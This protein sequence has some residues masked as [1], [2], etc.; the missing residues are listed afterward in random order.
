[1]SRHFK[2]VGELRKTI[3]TF[4]T[5]NQDLRCAKDD[6]K[7]Q[8]LIAVVHGADVAASAKPWHLAREWAVRVLREF[9]NQVTRVVYFVCCRMCA[10][11]CD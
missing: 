7:L 3:D 9:F 5:K 8:F 4:K 1:M 10:R 6:D 11:I 2:F